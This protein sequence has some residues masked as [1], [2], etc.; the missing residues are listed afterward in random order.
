[1]AIY[2]YD[3]QNCGTGFEARRMMKDADAPIACPQC[4]NM[5]ANRGLSLFFS[6]NSNSSANS[7]ITSGNGCGSCSSNS[8]ASCGSH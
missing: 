4:G 2:E 7:T 1:M 6:A 3:C 8:C 5:K